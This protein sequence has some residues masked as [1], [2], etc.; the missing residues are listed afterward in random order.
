MIMRHMTPAT[1]DELY[2]TPNL[3]TP[4]QLWTKIADMYQNKSQS[5]I[6]D[7]NLKYMSFTWKGSSVHENYE[8]FMWI[9]G[10]MHLLG[11]RK[12]PK[13]EIMQFLSSTPPR[14]EVVVDSILNDSSITTLQEART[15]LSNKERRMK[16]A[17]QMY[18]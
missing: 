7:L 16:T 1:A 18:L 17:K 5:K 9:V 15:V 4:H 12:S 2:N 6:K 14:Y 10:E 13:D 3:N 11:A 8:R